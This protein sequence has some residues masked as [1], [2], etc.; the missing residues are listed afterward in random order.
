MVC[1]WS[2]KIS[3]SFSRMEHLL[4]TKIV[5]K[6]LFFAAFFCQMIANIHL[7]ISFYRIR[8]FL[9]IS[10]LE[11]EGCA[12]FEEL[13]PVK[14]EI[15]RLLKIILYYISICFICMAWY[16]LYMSYF[17]KYACTLPSSITLVSE[18]YAHFSHNLILVCFKSLRVKL[19]KWKE[20]Q[21]AKILLT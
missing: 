16:I 21:L 14:T 1:F 18:L 9:K 4:L 13:L 19:S 15:G 10:W 5:N 12:Q 6:I 11:T 8:G 20:K 17:T 7:D 2:A 3:Y